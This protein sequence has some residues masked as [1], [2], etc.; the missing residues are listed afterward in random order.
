MNNFSGSTV[1]PIRKA[2]RNLHFS[3]W[4]F[5]VGLA[6]FFL[7]LSVGATLVLANMGDLLSDLSGVINSTKADYTVLTPAVALLLRPELEY[8]NLRTVVIGGDRL[9]WQ[10]SERWRARI[11]L[12]D[13]SVRL[14]FRFHRAIQFR[15]FCRY[16]PTEVTVHSIGKD[17]SSGELPEPGVIGH[18]LGSTHA[19]ILD[20]SRNVTPV[21][22]T[23]EL[24][25]CGEQVGRGY[26]NMPEISASAFLDNPFNSGER[27]YRTGD[28]ARW[29]CSGSIEFIGRQ[30]T[31]YIKLRGLRIDVAEIEAALTSVHGTM[32][33]VELLE[34]N[35]HP[36]LVGFLSKI[37]APAGEQPI[38]LVPT[39]EDHLAWVQERLDVCKR[40]VPGYAV[41]TQ[42]LVLEAMPQ[43]SSN[44][45]DRKRI[46]AFFDQ[47]SRQPEVIEQFTS[48][49]LTKEDDR[50]PLNEYEESLIGMW[51]EI[52]DREH[53][54]VHDD[55]S[56]IGGDS[57]KSVIL[58]S[59]IKQRGWLVSLKDFYECRT[60][61][62]LAE[63]VKASISSDAA[64]EEAIKSRGL[65]IPLQSCTAGE[66]GNAPIWM[67]HNGEGSFA[68]QCQS[69][70]LFSR[71]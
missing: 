46:R 71:V 27:M 1:F 32:A 36:H 16:G 56:I 2:K 42:W 68:P 14:C 26:F 20:S 44:K 39:P 9:P 38:S 41:P 8:P 54:S 6:D 50:A 59:R 63:V 11:T 25:L 3:P 69:L 4:S 23:G 66:T 62:R 22:V 17:H 45:I 10:L 34:L 5:D 67:I 43:A 57:I 29:T 12:I 31:G 58:L 51:K 19:Y 35:G 47:I 13:G 64:H 40:E 65:V 28:L 60:V 15:F 33:I 21:G 30:S 53:I 49:L 18:P 52:L 37:L 61:A 55:W 48:A 7:T 70:V 24:Y